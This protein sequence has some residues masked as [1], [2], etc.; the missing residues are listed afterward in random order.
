[1]KTSRFNHIVLPGIFLSALILLQGCGSSSRLETA[2]D[3][4]T[5][6][7]NPSFSTLKSP[8]D[9]C[10][11]EIN[12][13]VRYPDGT[14]F[15][16]GVVTISGGFAVPNVPGVNGLGLYQFYTAPNCAGTAVN[17]GFQGQTDDKGVYTFSAFIP[18]QVTLTTGLTT[19]N[20]FTDKLVA[21][22]GTAVGTTDF[23]F[24]Q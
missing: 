21:V 18:G 8:V 16:K 7:F 20:S 13:I 24:N 23:N 1:M 6:T 19:T 17:S 3:G 5:I 4:S 10:V 22:S 14:P 9:I 15:P 2:P 12:V 11:S